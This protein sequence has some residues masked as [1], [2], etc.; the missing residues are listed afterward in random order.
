MTYEQPP[1]D[2]GSRA[3]PPP[4][5]ADAL[6]R[7]GKAQ[8]REHDRAFA[9]AMRGAGLMG[10]LDDDELARLAASGLDDEE[11][12]AR[13]LDLA[14]GYYAAGGDSEAAARRRAADRFFAHT[15]EQSGTAAEL[16]ARLAALFPELEEVT[17]ERIG[18]EDGALVLHAGEERAA[19]VDAYEESL[20]TDE[21]DLRDIEGGGVAT[22]S[23]PSLVRALNELLDKHEVR[24][25]LVELR[26]DGARELYV[27]TGVTKAT[28][29]L[30][31]GHLEDEALEEL[32]DFASW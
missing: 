32:V 8:P 31:A 27:A 12:P 22:I 20:D 23:V 24:Q 2:A 14:Q 6:R 17:L 5:P 1:P 30:E 13:R 11:G 16:V 7:N 29:L 28:K 15:A 3:G 25:R 18:G 9:D 4:P 10:E 19:V 21:I 26:S